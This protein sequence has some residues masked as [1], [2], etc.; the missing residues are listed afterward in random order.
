[1]A[2]AVGRWPR[3]GRAGRGG[4][5]AGP[6]AGSA[7]LKLVT[8]RAKKKISLSSKY[9]CH[10]IQFSVVSSSI[11]ASSFSNNLWPDQCNF[12]HPAS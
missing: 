1:M 11:C 9:H 2:G 5:A 3:R 4:D 10:Q 12:L 6:V 7:G 8:L